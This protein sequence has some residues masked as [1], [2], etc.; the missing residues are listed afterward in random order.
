MEIWEV[1]NISYTHKY[2]QAVSGIFW[3]G[4]IGRSVGSCMD[5]VGEILQLP[6]ESVPYLEDIQPQSCR[7]TESVITEDKMG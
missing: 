2:W 5:S 3:P 1:P 6:V 7:T 4:N